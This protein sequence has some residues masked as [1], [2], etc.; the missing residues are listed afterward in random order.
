MFAAV[1]SVITDTAVVAGA[2]TSVIAALT[3]LGRFAPFRW[4]IRTL[5]G[6]PTRRWFTDAVHEAMKP[7]TDQLAQNGGSTLRDRVDV[8][9]KRLELVERNTRPDR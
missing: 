9:D 6:N 1:P 5:I 8:I 4:I 2:I 7:I 3:L